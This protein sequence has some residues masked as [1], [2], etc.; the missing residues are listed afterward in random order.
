MATF[1]DDRTLVILAS[2]EFGIIS[3]L[4]MQARMASNAGNDAIILLFSA[5]E[6][7]F[8]NVLMHSSRLAIARSRKGCAGLALL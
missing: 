4:A 3:S 2:V 8:G 6:Y 5:R 1:V 7:I